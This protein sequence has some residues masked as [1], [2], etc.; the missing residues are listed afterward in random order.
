MDKVRI[1]KLSVRCCVLGCLGLIPVLGV[2]PAVIAV[3]LFRQV[4]ELA[5]GQWNPASRYALGGLIAA[6]IGLAGTGMLVFGIL[7]VFLVA[8][9]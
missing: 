4:Q 2:G 5:S 1:I 6:S 7:W 3:R 8:N 9:G